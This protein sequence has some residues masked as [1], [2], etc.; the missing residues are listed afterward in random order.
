MPDA[1][2]LTIRPAGEGSASAEDGSQAVSDPSMPIDPDGE[3]DTLFR[4]EQD[5]PLVTIEN[6]D[7]LRRRGVRPQGWL[8]RWLRGLGHQPSPEQL[9]VMEEQR[10]RRL[11]EKVLA[12]DAKTWE[13]YMIN[14]L[15]RLGIAYV[16]R[17]DGEVSKKFRVSFDYIATEP[18]AIHYHVNMQR[19]PP[20]VSS[21]SLVSEETIR[22]LTMSVSRRVTCRWTAESGIWYTI[23]RASGRAGIRNHV[24]YQDLMDAMPASANSMTIPIGMTHNSRMIYSSISDWPHAL[25]AG[26]TGAGKSNFEHVAIC[27]LIQRNTP[28]QVQ[29]ILIDLKGGLE[30]TRYVGVPHL[31]VVMDNDIAPEGIVTERD[32]VQPLLGWLR[33][34]GEARMRQLLAAKASNIGEYNAHKRTNRLPFIC[35]FIDEW[36]DVRLSKIGKEAE[37]ELVNL[38]QRMR[39]VGIHFVVATQIPKSEVITGLIKG[40]LPCR[41]AFSVPNMHASM[42]IMDSGDAAGL[43]PVGRCIMQHRGET[44][45]QTPYIA[46][47]MIQAVIDQAITGRKSDVAGHDVTPREIMEWALAENNGWLTAR[48]LRQRY[49]Q[50]GITDAELMAWLK[51]WTWAEENQKE[52][53][54][55]SSSYRVVMDRASNGKDARRLVAIE[56]TEGQNDRISE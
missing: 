47:E 50:R 53:V 9:A 38:V 34:F 42:A 29:L 44:E 35:V 5:R 40:N 27:S 22:N 46:R 51:D 36:A 21:D 49:S 41:F 28:S 10:R 6:S 19:L 37:E 14:A 11:L 26:T 20:G 8:L 7:P 4:G 18:D 43:E 25:V 56:N 3:G 33:G 32:K 39:A 16:Q 45:I 13:G 23:E 2:R 24:K 52:F 17:K 55:G 31:R 54:I 1:K 48:A 15:E 12:A 30:F